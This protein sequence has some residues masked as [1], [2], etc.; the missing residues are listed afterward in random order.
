ML[1]CTETTMFIAIRLRRNGEA[2]QMLH[3]I[4]AIRL[5]GHIMLAT[6]RRHNDHNHGYMSIVRSYIYVYINEYEQILHMIIVERP[7]KETTLIC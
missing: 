3:L 6:I 1:I 5:G 4:V 2:E 7:C